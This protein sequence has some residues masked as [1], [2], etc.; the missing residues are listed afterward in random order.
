MFT[1]HLQLFNS[2]LHIYRQPSQEDII[3]SWIIEVKTQVN[4]LPQ[5]LFTE[6]LLVCTCI[7][8]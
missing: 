5:R 2:K 7:V 3:S 1:E 6:K 4:E 8:N